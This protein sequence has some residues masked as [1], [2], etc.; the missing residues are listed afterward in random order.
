M[1]HIPGEQ[2]KDTADAL[3]RCHLN[4]AYKKR[5]TKLVSDY[6]PSTRQCFHII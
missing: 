4:A 1:E 6:V 5:V 3:S 2:L